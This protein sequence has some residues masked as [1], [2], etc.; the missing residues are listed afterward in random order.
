MQSLPKERFSRAQMHL[1]GGILISDSFPDNEIDSKLTI[2]SP[3]AWV[4]ERAFHSLSS[5]PALMRKISSILL[6]LQN[7]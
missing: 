2:H 4:A 3:R 5:S 1:R 7:L 6:L